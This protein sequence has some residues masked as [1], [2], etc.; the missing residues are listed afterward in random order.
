VWLSEQPDGEYD[1]WTA[2]EAGP[3]SRATWINAFGQDR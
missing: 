1:L 2:F 3:V